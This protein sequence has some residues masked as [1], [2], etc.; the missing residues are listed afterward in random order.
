M[1]WHPRNKAGGL[2]GDSH[3]HEYPAVSPSRNLALG[4]LLSLRSARAEET[5]PEFVGT[6]FFGEETWNEPFPADAGIL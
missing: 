3:L 6:G 4:Y 5:L 1:R 2:F